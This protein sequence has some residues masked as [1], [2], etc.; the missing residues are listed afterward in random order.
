MASLSEA[1]ATQQVMAWFREW[2]AS[3]LFVSVAV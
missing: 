2:V 1:E 3:G